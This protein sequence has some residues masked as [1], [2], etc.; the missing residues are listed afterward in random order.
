MKIRE[1]TVTLSETPMQT[2]ATS[3]WRASGTVAL[4]YG[5]STSPGNVVILVETLPSD[6]TC[7]AINKLDASRDGMLH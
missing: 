1:L 3:R 2:P 6:G 5:L 4:V 7:P